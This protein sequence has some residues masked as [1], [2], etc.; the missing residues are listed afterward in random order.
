[1]RNEQA[2]EEGDPCV[3][4][5]TGAG[6]KLENFRLGSDLGDGMAGLFELEACRFS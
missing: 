5:G 3:E 2:V 6:G 1:M 4:A